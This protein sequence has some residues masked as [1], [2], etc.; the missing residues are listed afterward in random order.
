MLKKLTKHKK[1]HKFIKYFYLKNIQYLKIN[2]ILYFPPGRGRGNHQISGGGHN[3]VVLAR[4][5]ARR[6]QESG[7]GTPRGATENHRKIPGRPSLGRVRL[8]LDTG[9]VLR[10]AGG[11]HPDSGGDSG[12][13]V[14]RREGV[15]G[16]DGDDGGV[17]G[18]EH[19]Q[20]VQ[21]DSLVRW[22]Y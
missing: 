11:V 10:D 5:K 14:A 12:P 1:I 3:A 19:E 17:S 18:G 15:L 8:R 16:A 22:G 21:G 9:P 13:A 7:V 20:G 2:S 6:L 4:N